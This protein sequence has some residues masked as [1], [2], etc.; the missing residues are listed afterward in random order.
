MN[1]SKYKGALMKHEPS[2]ERFV[3]DR[4]QIIDFVVQVIDVN[5]YN[6]VLDY[7]VRI[8]F[9][10]KKRRG[11]WINEAALRRHHC[12]SFTDS[13]FNPLILMSNN[14]V[15]NIP[16]ADRTGWIYVRETKFKEEG[17]TSAFTKDTQTVAIKYA[18]TAYPRQDKIGAIYS[19]FGHDWATKTIIPV[20]EGSIKDVVG[21]YVADDLVSKREQ[22]RKSATDEIASALNLRNIVGTRLDLVNLDFNDDYEKAV[23]A[24]VVAVQRAAEAKNK[25]VQVK[26]EAEQ[27]VLGAKADA[28]AM[29][30][31]SQALSQNKGLVQYEA[32]QRWNG[33][34]PHIMLGNSTPFIDL[35]NVMK[36]EK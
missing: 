31:K 27:K 21:Q 15:R 16:P 10:K 3:V 24:K 13:M 12:N 4:L 22:A 19:Q 7:C 6:Y 20:I 25:T 36:E 29:R 11:W 23:E 33:E 26:E 32:V 8:K 34:L 17:E 35:R 2:G 5:G 30:I 1:L 18:L 28:E 14:T 9:V